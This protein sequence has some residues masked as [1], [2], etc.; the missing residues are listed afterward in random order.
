MEPSPSVTVVVSS[1]VVKNMAA[2]LDWVI[3]ASEV[4]LQAVGALAAALALAF[5]SLCC[6]CSPSFS[7][8]SR[9]NSCQ[10]LAI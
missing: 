2:E 4:L 1:P 8:G 6:Y 9:T 5:L 7:S 3:L 10:K